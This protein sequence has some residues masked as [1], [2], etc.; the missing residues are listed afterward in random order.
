MMKN[1]KPSDVIER[2][3]CRGIYVR[4]YN[5]EGAFQEKDTWVDTKIRSQF[6]KSRGKKIL[7]RGQ[8]RTS[9]AHSKNLVPDIPI[10]LTVCQT[11]CHALG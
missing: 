6:A 4:L 11:H 3:G 8:S 1:A 7:G 9:L 10:A 5:Q 2:M